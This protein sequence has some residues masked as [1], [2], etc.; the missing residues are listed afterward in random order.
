MEYNGESR[1][2]STHISQLIYDKYTTAKFFT[3]EDV[4][5]A[6][7]QMKNCPTS[8][9]NMEI[10]VRTNPLTWLKL[11]GEKLAMLHIGEDVEQLKCS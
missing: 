7:K 3:K 1:N 2:K 5:I 8:L 9:V 11:R 6:R 4:Q 10:Y